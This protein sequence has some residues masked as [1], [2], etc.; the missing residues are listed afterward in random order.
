M[1]ACNLEAHRW[2]VPDLT[3][4][5]NKKGSTKEPFSVAAISGSEDQ[6]R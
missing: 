3:T 4:D 2:D 6:K 5:P 1:D